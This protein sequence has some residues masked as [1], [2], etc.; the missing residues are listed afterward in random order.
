MLSNVATA[1]VERLHGGRIRQ[2]TMRAAGLGGVCDGGSWGGTEQSA[3]GG[4]R[5]AESVV[6]KKGG[7]EG[8]SVSVCV[9][10][11]GGQDR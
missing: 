4:G 11:P 10:P 1:G 7:S 8:E 2:R 5:R 3:E 9:W 6:V